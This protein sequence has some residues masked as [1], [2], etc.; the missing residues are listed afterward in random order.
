MNLLR[1]AILL[2]FATVLALGQ[3]ADQSQ[4]TN[5]PNQ[6]KVLVRS[7]YQQVVARHPTGLPSGV[8]MKIFAP[9]LSKTLLHRIDLADA[10][11]R[12]FFR[13][14]RDPNMKPPFAWLEAGLFS[15]EDE[16][17]SP[18]NFRIERTQAEQ[19]GSFRVDVRLTY[20]PTDGPGSWRVVAIVVREG[21]HFVVND[22]VYLKNENSSP[23][24]P[25]EWRLSQLLSQGCDGPYWIGYP[26]LS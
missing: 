1:C 25:A 7:L 26:P 15:G 16:K 12:D 5:L 11:E 10:C 3:P 21:G 19:D 14:H 23:L 17:T 20:R 6:P 18:G 8:D 4:P 13:K 9:Y 2:T 22:V 24:T